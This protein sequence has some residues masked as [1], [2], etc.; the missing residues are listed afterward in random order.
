[1]K[2]AETCS[3]SLCN[4]FYTYLYH[5][6]V[7]LD[8][9]YTAIHFIIN[10]TRM[11]NLLIMISCELYGIRPNTRWCTFS[12]RYHNLL[13]CASVPLCFT[14]RRCVLSTVP[15]PLL[16]RRT[17][18]LVPVHITILITSLNSSNLKHNL[19]SDNI[20]FWAHR[21]TRAGRPFYLVRYFGDN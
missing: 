1:M 9:T 8:S 10:K 3:C 13:S 19:L 18:N 6:I 5:H 2:S 15:P 17:C 12:A 4:K 20:T 16:W 7:V 11:T 14:H 21:F